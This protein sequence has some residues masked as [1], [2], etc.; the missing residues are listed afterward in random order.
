M[1]TM[2]QAVGRGLAAATALSVGSVLAVECAESTTSLTV[3]GSAYR[4]SLNKTACDLRLAVRIG[5]G[6]WMEVLQPATTLEFG[7]A[8]GS[9]LVTTL[10]AR[11]Q[12]AYQR[13]GAD[14]IIG[15]TILLNP[16][17]GETAQLH[18]ICVETGVLVQFLPQSSTPAEGLC[19][20]LPRLGL[21]ARRFS[22]YT[23]WAGD[24]QRHE[25]PL[26]NLHPLPAYAGVST[27]G[28]QGDTVA[29]LSPDL[30]AVIAR[31]TQTGAGVGVVLVDAQNAWRDGL[32]FLQRYQAGTLFFYAG[33]AQAAAARRGLWGW[34]APFDGRDGGACEKQVKQLLAQT[35]RLLRDF[36][37]VAPVIPPAWNVPADVP[38]SVRRAQPVNDISEAMVFTMNEEINSPYGMALARKTCSDVLVRAW[39]K[40][41]NA[42][43]WSGYRQFPVE[44]HALGML[45]GGGITCSALYEGENGLSA[46]EVRDMATRDPAGQLVDAWKSPGCRHGSLSNP[47]YLD[48]LLRWCRAQIDQGA[49]YLFMDEHNAALHP[50]EGYDDY[51]LR[52]FRD[53][54]RQTYCEQ[55]GW[56]A[57]DARWRQQFGLD[58]A[59]RALCPD[60]T[61]TSF[62]YRAWLRR[63]NFLAEPLA[64]KNSFRDAWLKFRHVRD[65]HAWQKLTDGIRAYA[66][67]KGRRVLIS[68]NGLAPRVDLQVLGVWGEW[69]VNN[70]RVEVGDSQLATWAGTVRRGHALAG[71]KVPVVFFHDWGFGEPPF[72]WLAVPPADRALWMRV[73]GAEIYAAGGRFAFPVT[74]PF[75][76]DALKDGTLG[77]IAQLTRFYHEH[78]DLY[79]HAKTIATD[80]LVTEPDLGT[81]LALRGTS[82]AVLLHVINHATRDHQ[83]QARQNIGVDLPLTV[84]PDSVQVFSPDGTG[85][86]RLEKAGDHLRVRLDKLEAYSVV[87][88]NY[89]TLPTL[90]TNFAPR[91]VPEN[92]WEKPACNEFVVHPGGEVENAHELVTPLQGRLHQ[93]LRNPP[94][95]IVNAPRGGELLVRVRAVATAGARLELREGDRVLQTFDLPDRDGKNDAG[96]REWECTLT[97]ALPAGQHRLTLDNTG[98]DWAALDWLCFSG[99]FAEPVFQALERPR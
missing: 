47:R 76:C 63:N 82:P 61:L 56:S 66:A 17:S 50:N 36:K 86:A 16:L 37:P 24:G 99:D 44:A 59:D 39:F 28:R 88:L 78:G 97:F 27:W 1:K 95:F 23:F 64:A 71:R 68:A 12:M 77:T 15:A 41:H 85:A 98:G 69:R 96:A 10:A 4:L 91:L 6:G 62:D 90:T 81:A 70:N 43:D 74:G 30:P 5:D 31:D 2:L 45:F 33:N 34:L 35:P 19:W 14:L 32:T 3:T 53:W 42:P 21:D 58:V 46:A 54:L 92:R 55:Q 38:A 89:T 11:T 29:R 67:G 22:A 60:G 18:L 26:E 25:G 57:T 79:R 94:V 7:I 51:A 20:A 8:R 75:G 83:L 93:P 48:Y 72:P 13:V 73:R 49:D 80:A 87:V 40:W 65:A 84:Q 52:D 9:E